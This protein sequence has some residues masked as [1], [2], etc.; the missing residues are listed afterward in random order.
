ML[1]VWGAETSHLLGHRP[2]ISQ[3]RAVALGAHNGIVVVGNNCAQVHGYLLV[4]SGSWCACSAGRC[5][6]PFSLKSV[7]VEMD[8]SMALDNSCSALAVYNPSGVNTGLQV[9]AIVSYDRSVLLVNYT[10]RERLWKLHLTPFIATSIAFLAPSPL[11][12]NGHASPTDGQLELL[13]SVTDGTILHWCWE[14]QPDLTCRSKNGCDVELAASEGDLRPWGQWTSINAER[15]ELVETDS[16][17]SSTDHLPQGV[18]NSIVYL[19]SVCTLYPL[20][21]FLTLTQA[22]IVP[23][24]IKYLGVISRVD[25]TE[26]STEMQPNVNALS[27]NR[28]QVL[29]PPITPLAQIKNTIDNFL[30]AIH[31]RLMNSVEKLQRII[32]W[33]SCSDSS[34]TPDLHH[35]VMATRYGVSILE[36]T[37]CQTDEFLASHESNLTST[38]VDFEV[39]RLIG[40]KIGNSASQIQAKLGAQ[41]LHLQSPSCNQGLNAT[42]CE[43]N[44]FGRTAVPCAPMCAVGLADSRRGS[45]CLTTQIMMKTQWAKLVVYMSGRATSLQL[46]PV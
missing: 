17:R 45:V 31:S 15:R 9:L 33:A 40:L 5:D 26:I 22:A 27:Q 25:G 37:V 28:S 44:R 36:Q 21:G 12:R 38:S 4:G 16:Q 13:I 7:T 43:G 32:A 20:S 3:L 10:S 39:L 30:G 29:S 1:C 8:S 46:C 18:R 14:V 19:E 41:S 6:H 35:I 23:I 11:D 2:H 24:E 42:S 34:S